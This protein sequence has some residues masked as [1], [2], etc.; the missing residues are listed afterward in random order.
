[1][2]A[3]IILA[4]LVLFLQCGFPLLV[5]Q[6]GMTDLLT[7]DTETSVS[8]WPTAVAV[9]APLVVIGVAVWTG[10]RLG[11]SRPGAWTAALLLNLVLAAAYASMVVWTA[12]AESREGMLAFS[13]LVIGAP[14][15][16]MS[17]IGVGLLLARSTRL[18]CLTSP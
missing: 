5:F 3:P 18:Y 1:V 8:R 4:R 2:T 15:V 7:N 10:L 9:Y 6:A 11:R 14:L 16:L 13:G 17:L 12:T